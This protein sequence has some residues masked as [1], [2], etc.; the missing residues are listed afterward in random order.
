[1]RVLFGVKT[2]EMKNL[3]FL[4]LIKSRSSQKRTAADI[5]TAF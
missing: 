4:I 1:M 2:G 5:F 3:I